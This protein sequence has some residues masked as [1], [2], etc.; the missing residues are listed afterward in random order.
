LIDNHAVVVRDCVIDQTMSSSSQ[1]GDGLVVRQVGTEGAP[2]VVTLSGNVVTNSARLGLAVA[3]PLAATLTNNE[4]DASN[5]AAIDGHARFA[6]D[7][8]AVSGDVVHDLDLDEHRVGRL[9][10]LR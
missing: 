6:T 5:G 8:A 7:N 2:P 4:A 10:R 9:Y 3:G 1:A